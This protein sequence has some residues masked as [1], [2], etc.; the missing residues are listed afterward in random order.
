MGDLEA[1]FV[2]VTAEELQVEFLVIDGEYLS[3]LFA[4]GQARFPAP[5]FP[6]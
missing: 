1:F 4:H 3:S 2:E 5:I 6:P